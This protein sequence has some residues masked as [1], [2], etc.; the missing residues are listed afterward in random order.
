MSYQVYFDE[1]KRVCIR[2]GDHVNRSDRW[3]IVYHTAP[4]PNG[5]FL[6]WRGDLEGPK[7]LIVL[8]TSKKEPISMVDAVAHH[9]HSIVTKGNEVKVLMDG[10]AFKY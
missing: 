5:S 10:F 2:H 9:S 7:K 8:H 3:P 6:V 4:I 1:K